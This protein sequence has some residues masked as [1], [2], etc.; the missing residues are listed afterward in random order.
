MTTNDGKVEEA[1]SMYINLSQ[2]GRFAPYGWRGSLR[3]KASGLIRVEEFDKEG[4]LL[5]EEKSAI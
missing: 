1:R 4:N 2:I 3:F 5:T